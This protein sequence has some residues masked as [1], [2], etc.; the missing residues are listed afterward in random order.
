MSA[1]TVVMS[2]LPYFWQIP[3]QYVMYIYYIVYPA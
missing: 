1:R 2:V 3:Q